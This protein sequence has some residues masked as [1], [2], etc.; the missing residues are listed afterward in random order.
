MA[1]GRKVIY[2][3]LYFYKN[4]L[5]YP[6]I[7]NFVF[8]FI[9]FYSPSYYFWFIV[10]TLIFFLTN[11]NTPLFSIFR[12]ISSCSLVKYLNFYCLSKYS[13]R[14][15]AMYSFW[16]FGI[17]WYILPVLS[18]HIIIPSIPAFSNTYQSSGTNGFSSRS[19]LVL[20]TT[21][22]LLYLPLSLMHQNSCPTFFQYYTIPFLQSP[23]Q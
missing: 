12:I 23:Y 9:Y 4:G 10:Q 1:D 3:T 2:K 13:A 21:S 14:E 16:P 5:S 8:F 6:T 15:S 19:S 7:I 17:V 22:N 20:R 18:C 11:T